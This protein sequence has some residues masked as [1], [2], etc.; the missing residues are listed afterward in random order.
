MNERNGETV[1]VSIVIRDGR[2]FTHHYADFITNPHDAER[3]LAVLAGQRMPAT[4]FDSDSDSDF[5]ALS[6]LEMTA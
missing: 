5:G 4:S 6:A 1:T 2:G 3:A